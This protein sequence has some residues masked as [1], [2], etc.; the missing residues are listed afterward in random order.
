M[1]YTE[2]VE[3]AKAL[4]KEAGYGPDNPLK[5]QLRYN[6]HVNHE[7]IAIAVQAMWKQIGV[8]AELFNSEVAVHY[9]DLESGVFDVARA[10]WIADYNDAQTFLGLLET[11]AGAQN[12]G[13]YSSPKFDELMEKA[14][15]T[16]DLD[17]RGK[18]MAEAEAIAMQEHAWIPVYY[19][20]SKDLVS[21]KVTGWVDN[22]FNIHRTR[23]ITV[24]R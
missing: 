6:T 8:E 1:P 16:A 10:G 18:I 2:R 7:K 23:W 14:S 22:V 19:Y 21:T 24:Q 12:Y 20:V 13:R 15:L 5:F 17:A 9:N 11:R 3:K 4:L